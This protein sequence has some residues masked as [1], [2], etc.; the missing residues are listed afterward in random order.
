[1]KNKIVIF[2]ILSWVLI[3]CNTSMQD[4]EILNDEKAWDI[5][6][7]YMIGKDEAISSTFQFFNGLNEKSRADIS[8]NVMSVELIR[9]R[10]SRTVES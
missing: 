7:D 3:S 6:S 8:S 5:L 1:M 10:P 9:S 4:Q 2:V